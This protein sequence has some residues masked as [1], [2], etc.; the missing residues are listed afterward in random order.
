MLQ[1]LLKLRLYQEECRKMVRLLLHRK[2]LLVAGS[3]EVHQIT[4]HE[5]DDPYNG[6]SSGRIYCIIY[7]S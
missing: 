7:V 1:P 2:I 6:A 3:T 4:D 5:K